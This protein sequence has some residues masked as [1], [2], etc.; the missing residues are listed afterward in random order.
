MLSPETEV[1]PVSTNFGIDSDWEI[2]SYYARSST[3]LLAG[4][5][6]SYRVQVDYNGDRYGFQV[7][8]LMVGESFNPEI[9]F[10]RRADFRL[11]SALARFSPR[12]SSLASIRRLVWQAGLDYLTDES[13]HTL[14]SREAQGLVQGRAPEQRLVVDPVRTSVRT[15]RGFFPHRAKAGY[16]DSPWGL[17]FWS[18]EH[19]IPARLAAS[20]ERSSQRRARKFLQRGSDYRR[21]QRPARVLSAFFSGAES[22]PELDRRV[23]PKVS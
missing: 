21:V 17:P 16:R 11:S 9:G 10:M 8:H 20:G 2:T 3:P 12:P 15:T 1:A 18:G 23:N 6:A 5:D 7:G 22:L 14:K 13:G 4:K 19:V